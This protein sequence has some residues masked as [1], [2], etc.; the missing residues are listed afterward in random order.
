M[1]IKTAEMKRNAE[2]A[3]FLKIKFTCLKLGINVNNGNHF[4]TA[5]TIVD[6]QF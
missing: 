3:Y 4:L 2:H 6:A 5:K 1:K